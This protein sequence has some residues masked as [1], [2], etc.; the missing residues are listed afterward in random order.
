MVSTNFLSE[1]GVQH[2]LRLFRP[3]WRVNPCASGAAE[4]QS[5]WGLFD[6]AAIHVRHGLELRY[7]CG[8][9]NV[10]PRAACGLIMDR[11]LL[12]FTRRVSSVSF[13]A[14]SWVSSR[15]ACLRSLAAPRFMRR[16]GERISGPWGSRWFH[17]VVD[18]WRPMLTSPLGVRACYCI[19][20]VKR[21]AGHFGAGGCGLMEK[22]PEQRRLMKHIHMIGIGGS[23]MSPLVA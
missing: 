14:L 5:G 8:D 21:P 23:A 9:L 4:V 2:R 11:A 10:G 16:L 6:G 1:R 20:T 13:A 15:I 18:T 12:H 19:R 17:G 3:N 22:T 7:H